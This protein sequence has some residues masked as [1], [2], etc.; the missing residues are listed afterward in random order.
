MAPT[1]ATV[2]TVTKTSPTGTVEVEVKVAANPVTKTPGT[3]RFFVEG[4]ALDNNP[5]TVK[6]NTVPRVT[7][8]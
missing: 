8:K 1:E 6:N 4:K 5:D 7:N 3:W 2:T